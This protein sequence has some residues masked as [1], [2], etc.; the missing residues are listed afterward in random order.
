MNAGNKQREKTEKLA[1]MGILT[2][3]V[4]VLSYFGGF[5]KIG[6]LASVN[7]TLIPVVLGSAIYGPLAGAWL[8]AVASA[9]FFTTADAAFW[10]GLSLVGTVVTVFLKGILAGVAAGLV[11]RL[12]EKKNR[13]LAVMAGAVIAPVVNTGLFLAGCMVFF[14]DAVNEMAAAGGMSVGAYLIVV[15]VGLNFVF[16]LLFGVI[17][18][19]GVY[20]LLEHFKAMKK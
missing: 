18:G 8:G 6:S 16:E 5:I 13:Y 4:M 14:I 7:L 12:L 1:M 10:V 19:P 9:I 2:A 15:F 3:L 20:R 17:L 11:Y